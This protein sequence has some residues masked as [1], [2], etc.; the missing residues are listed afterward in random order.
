MVERKAPHL[1]PQSVV[2]QRFPRNI[3]GDVKVA[4]I[5][6]CP[7]PSVL[8]RYAPQRV[9]DQ[10]FIHI[11][12][13]SVRKTRFRLKKKLNLGEQDD[14]DDFITEY[15]DSNLPDEKLN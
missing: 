4:L 3:F 2:G 8:E 11:S 15:N 7:P 9:E 12:P 1:T 14:L 13:D 10:H 5:G 6:Y